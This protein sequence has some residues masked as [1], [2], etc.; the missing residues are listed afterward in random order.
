MVEIARLW[1]YDFKFSVYPAEPHQLPHCHV[2]H[3]GKKATID[4]IN[5]KV[6]RGTLGS[7]PESRALEF[8]QRHQQEFLD[9]WRTIQ[10]GK[11][12]VKIED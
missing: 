8:V 2:I 6:I 9:A 3:K 7:R 12:P 1:Q 5:I 11:I 10:A 4:L